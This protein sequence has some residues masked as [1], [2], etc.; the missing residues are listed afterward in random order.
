MLLKRVHGSIGIVCGDK[1]NSCRENAK[2]V[3][4]RARR[5]EALPHAEEERIEQGEEQQLCMEGDDAVQ[6]G[7]P[8]SIRE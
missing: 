5:E 8:E 2:L 3:V 7:A 6:A 4:S 1:A